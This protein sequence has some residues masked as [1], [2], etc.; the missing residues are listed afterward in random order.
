[1]KKTAVLILL[2]TAY[3]V[4]AEDIV[5]DANS[6]YYKSYQH[7]FNRVYKKIYYHE[8]ILYRAPGEETLKF[9]R[10]L[11]SQTEGMTDEMFDYNSV[12][13]FCLE[14]I[15]GGDLALGAYESSRVT[16]IALFV[17]PY[18]DENFEKPHILVDE[19]YFNKEQI[20]VF[21]SSIMREMKAAHDYYDRISKDWYTEWDEVENTMYLLDSYYF[22]AR[23]IEDFFISRQFYITNF[24]GFLLTNYHD[25][26]LRSFMFYYYGIDR[27]TLLAGYSGQQNVREG[28]MSID[29]Y[30]KQLYDWSG[31][32]RFD[33]VESYDQ[34]D[35]QAMLAIQYTYSCFYNFILNHLAVKNSAM[36]GET[37]DRYGE[38]LDRVFEYYQRNEEYIDDFQNFVISYQTNLK[39]LSTAE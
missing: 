24:E 19:K 38:L 29:D 16:D 26:Y 30:I 25:E 37:S 23:F 34:S 33:E 4:S 22:Q 10:S 36:S 2:F 32:G 14:K 20:S 18:E 39:P 31:S 12:V 15:D 6:G 9:F 3:F 13:K 5:I 21:L 11:A 1:M 28:R 7:N 27:D 35:A 8:D 17:S